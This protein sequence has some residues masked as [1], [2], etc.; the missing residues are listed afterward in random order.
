MTTKRV[1]AKDLKKGDLVRWNGAVGIIEGRIHD[2]E[3]KGG[4]VRTI[5][6]E[7]VGSCA[8]ML[9]ADEKIEVVLL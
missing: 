3:E 2:I 4:G 5:R 7:P 8:R 9:I 1:A 6:L